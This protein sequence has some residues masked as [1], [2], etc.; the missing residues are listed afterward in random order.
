MA[1]FFGE[2]VSSGA[3]KGTILP[4]PVRGKAPAKW[5]VKCT[6]YRP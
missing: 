3:T 1:S 2:G 6:L 5:L 4:P